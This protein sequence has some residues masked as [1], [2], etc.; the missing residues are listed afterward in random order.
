MH[1]QF[2]KD[3]IDNGEL[4]Y[5]KGDRA[6][7][8]ASVGANLFFRKIAERVK[9]ASYVERLAATATEG[10][11]TSNTV[12]N[13][14]VGVE[15][16]IGNAPISAVPVLFRKSGTE[17]ARILTVKQAKSLNVPKEI[18]EQFRV[19]LV[20]FEKLKESGGSAGAAERARDEQ[21]RYNA[22]LQGAA[23]KYLG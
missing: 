10:H 3:Y 17:V 11:D 13:F 21:A 12:V 15:Y 2:I 9:Y 14:V 18:V 23:A 8:E 4:L 20:A 1:I 19:A 7:V 22:K 6:H 16:S 5:R